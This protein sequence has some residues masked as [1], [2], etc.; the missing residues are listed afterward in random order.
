[1]QARRLS[2]NQRTGKAS[3]AAATTKTKTSND[4]DNISYC[5]CLDEI[6]R[7]IKW[8]LFIVYHYVRM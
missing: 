8:E 5:F 1:M 3:Q 6:L 4:N 2:P 7:I